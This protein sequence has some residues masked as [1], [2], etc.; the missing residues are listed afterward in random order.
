[1][2]DEQNNSYE[3]PEGWYASSDYGAYKGPPKRNRGFKVFLLIIAAIVACTLLVLSGIGIYSLY[4]GGGLPWLPALP[5]GQVPA[6]EIEQNEPKGDPDGPE[7]TIADRPDNPIYGE[8][9]SGMGIPEI[10]EK[11]RPSVVGVLAESQ[12]SV[13]SGSGVIMSET[14]YIITNAHVIENKGAVTVVTADETRYEARVVGADR[15]TDLAV[16]KIDA[17]NLLAAEFGASSDLVVG[18]LAV[19]IGNPL[20]MELFG[21]VTAG[22]I[23]ALDRKITFEDRTMVLIQT[24]AAINP[25]NSGGALVNGYG[26]II[27]INSAKIVSEGYT[28]TSYEGLGFAIP[29]DSAK[30]I[31]DSLI[32][33][34]YVPG[35]PVIGIVGEDVTPYY[36]EFFH[37][38]QGV[39]IHGVTEGTDAV[40]KG[41]QAGDIV[42]AIN[43]TRVSSMAELN[44]IK[45]RFKTGD[46]VTLTIDRA[47]KE[48]DI[49]IT[50]TESKG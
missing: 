21:S 28:G 39:Y 25:G 8:Q 19:A 30:P 40:G 33:L 15:K 4:S 22:I 12:E 18:E 27:G 14:G 9:A 3:R 42:V 11:V 23:S 44:E 31:V 50:L 43:G 35:R 38:P 7:L 45:D 2:S 13:L 41:I 32:K 17:Q 1:M 26:Q 36:S 37:R 49:N 47:G 20:G 10:A 16:L 29:I 48:Y 46:V 6:P 34:G 24:D 5:E